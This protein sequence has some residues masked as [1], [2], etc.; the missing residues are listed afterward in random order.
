[1]LLVGNSSALLLEVVYS[2]V[3]LGWDD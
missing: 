3:L 1:L 2:N